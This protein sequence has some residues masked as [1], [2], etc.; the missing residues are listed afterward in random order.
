MPAIITQKDK[1][2]YFGELSLAIQ[3]E[4]SENM[5]ESKFYVSYVLHGNCGELGP[6]RTFEQ[7]QKDKERLES[8]PAFS[9][10]HIVEK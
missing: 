6:Y 7:A 10:V 1:Y 3:K 9:D 8:R 4:G 5:Q 2:V